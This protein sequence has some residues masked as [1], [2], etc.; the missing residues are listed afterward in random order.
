MAVVE[1]AS[2]YNMEICKS[3]LGNGNGRGDSVELYF[4][5]D[6]GKEVIGS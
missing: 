3:R 2:R 5:C 4:D 6:A 1:P